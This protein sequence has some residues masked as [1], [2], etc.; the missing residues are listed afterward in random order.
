MGLWISNSNPF[1]IWALYIQR[2][3]WPGWAWVDVVHARTVSLFFW[4][5]SNIQL[6][7]H[8]IKSA[9]FF[10]TFFSFFFPLNDGRG[11]SIVC[12]MKKWAK[13]HLK[14]SPNWAHG[15]SIQS[16]LPMPSLK[17]NKVKAEKP[18][19]HWKFGTVQMDFQCQQPWFSKSTPLISSS[20]IEGDF[21]N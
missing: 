1:H 21:P 10:I 16:G 15:P 8:D 6:K 13:A 14:I 20:M 3:V 2:A 9:K 7:N 4:Y 17:E 18:F 11:G 5:S 12:P 19:Q